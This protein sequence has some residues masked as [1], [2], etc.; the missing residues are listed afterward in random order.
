MIQLLNYSLVLFCWVLCLFK[1][2]IWKCRPFVNKSQQEI[3]DPSPPPACLRCSH[4]RCFLG[5]MLEESCVCVD[6]GWQGSL[7]LW[8]LGLWTLQYLL[9]FHVSKM[10]FNLKETSRPRSEKKTGTKAS[11]TVHPRLWKPNPGCLAHGLFRHLCPC[12]LLAFPAA[13]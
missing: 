4:H 13:R 6:S 5:W 3:Q 11:H 10:F 12:C 2:K 8:L 9:A 7:L 1:S